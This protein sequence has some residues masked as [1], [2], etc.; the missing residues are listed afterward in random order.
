M[1]FKTEIDFFEQHRKEWFEHNAGKIAV[2]HGTTLYGFYDT[3]ETAL[4]VGYDKCGVESSFLM[5]EV[6]LD[7]RIETIF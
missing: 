1:L 3:Y 6:L 7:D 5:K 4:E 2:V